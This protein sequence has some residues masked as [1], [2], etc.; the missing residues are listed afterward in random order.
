MCVS[1]SQGSS[2]LTLQPCTAPPSVAA[3]F[4]DTSDELVEEDV[5][6]GDFPENIVML[7]SATS[8][9]FVITQLSNGI[10]IKVHN[11]SAGVLRW[12]LSVL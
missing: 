12:G 2:V 4:Y 5:F 8:L 3:S 7:G 11:Y 9:T 6:N 10:S 1:S